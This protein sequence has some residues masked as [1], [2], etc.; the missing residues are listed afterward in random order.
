MMRKISIVFAA[1]CIAAPVWAQSTP[2]VR[3]TVTK[4]DTA[5]EKI[6]IRHAPIPNLDMGEMTMVFRVGT[7]DMLK[8][9]KPGENIQFTAERVNG[10]ITLTSIRK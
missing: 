6:T 9:V 3:G 8:Q 2:L 5:A 4:V 7:A 1:L 10:Q